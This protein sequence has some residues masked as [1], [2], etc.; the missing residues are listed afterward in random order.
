MN[1]D[2]ILKKHGD[3]I[4]FYAKHMFPPS[5]YVEK[6]TY[7]SHVEVV[8]KKICC[9]CLSEAVGGLFILFCVGDFLLYFFV[10]A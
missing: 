1:A 3:L 5:T 9:F 2:T 10:M 8:L 7:Q 6:V 4:S